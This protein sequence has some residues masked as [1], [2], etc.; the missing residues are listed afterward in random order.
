MSF[1]SQYGGAEGMVEILGFSVVT[2]LQNESERANMPSHYSLISYPNPFNPE[3]VIS[4]HL[5]VGSDINLSIYNALGQKVETLVTGKKT[6]GM[7][8]IR[9]NASGYA[10]GIYL[11]RLETST[12]QVM[13]NKMIL[14][15]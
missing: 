12:G 10:A 4:Y 9:W 7:H 2:G 6:T 1:D 8:T 5:A 14:L 13:S 11:S 3:T 15:K